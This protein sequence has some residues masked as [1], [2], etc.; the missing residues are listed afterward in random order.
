MTASY[1]DEFVVIVRWVARILAFLLAILV[2]FLVMSE[3]DF[4]AKATRD[5][6]Q[7]LIFLV[8]WAGLVFA[9]RWDGV[10]GTMITG[11]TVL[12]LGLDFFFTGEPLRLW[13][14]LIFLLPGISFLYCWWH[15]RKPQPVSV[16]ESQ[17]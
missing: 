12:L 7:K 4:S 8:I 13:L 17:K 16:V 6:A 11:G 2:F 10:G 5:I 1:T 14:F 3:A 9:L 15:S